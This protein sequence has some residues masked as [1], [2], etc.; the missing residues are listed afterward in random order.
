MDQAYGQFVMNGKSMLAHRA[1]YELFVGPIPEGMLVLHTCDLPLCVKPQH[2][3]LGT[4]AENMRDAIRK[5]RLDRKALAVG[6]ERD[7]RG[8]FAETNP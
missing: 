2:L 6:F 1:S 5:G 7:D 8:R 4:Q 3:W